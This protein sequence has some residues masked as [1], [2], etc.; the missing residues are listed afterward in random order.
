MKSALQATDIYS[1]VWP[2]YFISKIFGLA[3]YNLTQKRNPEKDRTISFRLFQIWSLFWVILLVARGYISTSEKYFESITLKRRIVEIMFSVSLYSCGII[4][5]IL[6]LTINRHKVPQIIEKFSEI[7]HLLSATKYEHPTYRNTR[8]YIII[9]FTVFISILL[10]IMSYDAYIIHCHAN[11]LNC[12]RH[13][14]EVL[15]VFLNSIVILQFVDLVLLLWNKY[16]C[17]NSVLE[18]SSLVS[19]ITSLRRCSNNHM[20]PIED[21]TFGK[22]VFIADFSRNTP[23]SRRL[24]FRNLRT[25]YSQLYDV[26]LLINSTYGSALILTTFWVF[27]SIISTANFVFEL[28]NTDLYNY[29]LISVLWSGFCVTLVA[30]MAVSCSLAICE[31]NRSPIVV[32]KIILR[33]DI[34]G[35]TLK[36]L[37]NM[38]TQ[39]QTMKIGFTACGLFSLD[40][41]FLSGIIGIT[42]SYVLIIA[43]F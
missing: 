2:L 24:R 41:S 15:P 25:I 3:P 6:S 23:L 30:T 18:T 42:I 9:Q 26:A 1:A 17:L 11:L 21:Y 28:K 4:S 8:L 19:H 39:F 10:S 20:T 22:K 31:C 7:D 32:Q 37:K 38:F 43:Q 40:L 5:L 13:F 29:V 36:E 27:I 12:Y 16:K 34:D 35:E 14:F 33:V